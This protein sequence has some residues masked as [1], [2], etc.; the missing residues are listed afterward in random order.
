MKRFWIVSALALFALATLPACTARVE[1][2][3]Q[4]PEFEQTQE[5]QLPSVDVEPAEVEV[6]TAPLEVPTDV[7]V[8]PAP[9]AG[10]ETV[11]A[12]PAPE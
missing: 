9:E 2:E 11:P 5:G 7:N 1:E 4:L 3:G 10:V 6:E 8:Q 12:E